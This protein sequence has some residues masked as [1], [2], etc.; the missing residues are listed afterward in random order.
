M[1]TFFSLFFCQKIERNLFNQEDLPSTFFR[2]HNITVQFKHVRTGDV[3]RSHVR[4]VTRFV[5]RF[6]YIVILENE[7]CQENQKLLRVRPSKA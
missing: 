4:I 1:N 2:P 3:R 5:C 6:A 7:W